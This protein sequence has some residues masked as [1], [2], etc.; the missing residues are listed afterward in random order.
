[1]R[2]MERIR[3]ARKI[4]RAALGEMVHINPVTIAKYEKGKVEPG[5][6]NALKIADALGV[7]VKELVKEG[8]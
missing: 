2:N 7:D 3:K 1:M 4:S 6:M 8:A 5:L